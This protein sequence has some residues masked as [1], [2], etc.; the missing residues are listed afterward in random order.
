MVLKDVIPLSDPL[1]TTGA[2]GDHL[3]WRVMGVS[4]VYD[5]NCHHHSGHLLWSSQPLTRTSLIEDGTQGS[6]QLTE[7]WA[8]TWA[9][10][11]SANRQ[12]NLHIFKRLCRSPALFWLSD[13]GSSSNDNSLSKTVPFGVKNFRNIL[14]HRLPKYKS[15]RHVVLHIW[16]PQYKASPMML[17]ICFGVPALLV[18]TEASISLFRIHNADLMN[19]HPRDH[20][21][22][23]LASGCRTHRVPQWLTSQ[24]SMK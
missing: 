15:R 10:D 18:V 6:A 17:L 22:P 7:H 19:K 1:A 24:T 13:R 23:Y 5:R 21:L 16:K 8:V 9:L 12:S 2:P 11:A 4:L 14:P 3:R 20:S